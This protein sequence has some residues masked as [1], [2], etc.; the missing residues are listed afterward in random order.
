[1]KTALEQAADVNTRQHQLILQQHEVKAKRYKEERDELRAEL[2]AV[3]GEAGKGLSQD[4]AILQHENEWKDAEI[5]RLTDEVYDLQ[6]QL[7]ASQM[8]ES[9]WRIQSERHEAAS[10]A[11]NQSK[12]DAFEQN[13]RLREAAN[14]S[15]IE[16]EKSER[17]L[18]QSLAEQIAKSVSTDLYDR[19]N[20]RLQEAIQEQAGMVSKKEYDNAQQKIAELTEILSSRTRVPS[21]S[22]HNSSSSSRRESTSPAI[23]PC[24]PG[25]PIGRTAIASSSAGTS[26][27]VITTP[28]YPLRSPIN[29]SPSMGPPPS[30][31]ITTSKSGSTADTPSRT[32]PAQGSLPSSEPIGTVP[33]RGRRSL[34]QVPAQMVGLGISHTD[35]AN[36]YSTVPTP[37]YSSPYKPLPLQHQMHP[38]PRPA[39]N[40]HSSA[41]SASSTSSKESPSTLTDKMAPVQTLG[42]PHRIAAVSDQ[43]LKS[44]PVLQQQQATGA[45]LPQPLRHNIPSLV[46][47][48]VIPAAHV[49]PTM[50]IPY[51]FLK[52][53]R[54]EDGEYI[55]DVSAPL[56]ALMQRHVATWSAQKDKPDW[57]EKTCASAKRCV[58][59]RRVFVSLQRNPPPTDPQNSIACGRCIRRGQLC[60]LV[61]DRGPVAVP[62]PADERPP[63][64]TP[65]DLQYFVRDRG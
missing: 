51:K 65:Q 22:P 47:Q 41:G 26:P 2:E 32:L 44:P 6:Q 13:L 4:V 27:R 43:Q 30:P 17:L 59:T 38:P 11:A 3:K 33:R 20:R 55:S 1:M 58:D 24:S 35:A 12:A 39:P 45:I 62:L 48:N 54:L 34:D 63:S 16:Q 40:R 14:Q 57:R 5:D 9:D 61:G 7:E 18:R 28:A 56:V 53:G 46:A 42:M 19:V 31:R 50:S 10:T 64:A 37:S 60:V 21:Y 8:A 23:V 36:G 15:T 29:G 52:N 49:N 25:T